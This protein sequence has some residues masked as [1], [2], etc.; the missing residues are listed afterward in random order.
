VRERFYSGSA[1]LAHVIR[2][3]FSSDVFVLN[4][5][6]TGLFVGAWRTPAD[7]SMKAP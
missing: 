6:I 7:C 5:C 4:A 3:D 1:V 2:L